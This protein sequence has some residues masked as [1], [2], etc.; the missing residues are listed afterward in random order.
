MMKNSITKTIFVLVSALS[1]LATSSV[2]AKECHK[3]HCTAVCKYI[4]QSDL[5]AT[6]SK[7]GVYRICSN[8]VWNSPGAAITV[9]SDDVTI[10]FKNSFIDI[11]N[12]AGI[13]VEA[14]GVHNL[15]LV[16]PNLL[17]HV[18]A[19]RQ[20]GTYRGLV[21]TNS[22]CLT[23]TNLCAENVTDALFTDTVTAIK[24]DG[25]C[26]NNDTYQLGVT[27][28]SSSNILHTN[29]NSKNVRLS[30]TSSID[31]YFS[32]LNYL[33]DDNNP[34][35]GT[36]T[37]RVGAVLT[38]FIGP[39]PQ[40]GYPSKNLFL[41]DVNIGMQALYQN[42]STAAIGVAGEDIHIERA[43]IT[44]DQEG[45]WRG[46]INLSL[47]P[48][49]Q[50]VVKDCSLDLGG[51]GVGI[52]FAGSY[53]P[54]F[55][56]PG[57]ANY[58]VIDGNRITNAQ[59]GITQDAIV[60]LEGNDVGCLI[61]N[62]HV[63][64]CQIGIA[65]VDANNTIVEHNTVT[66]CY[67]GYADSDVIQGRA[68]AFSALFQ[69]NIAFANTIN[70]SFISPNTVGIDNTDVRNGEPFRAFSLSAVKNVSDQSQNAQM[71]ELF[72]KNKDRMFI[73]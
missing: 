50:I 49:H 42:R 71:A 6:L 73:Q 63:T 2:V 58:C 3:S 36:V 35:G 70:Y 25:V 26:I 45:D 5:P 4:E 11:Q 32:K 38:G 27:Y 67:W 10:E 43:N 1:S 44:F 16:N 52:I 56:L 19:S 61:K 17:G 12:P 51:Q 24:T 9:A 21:V 46:I 22:E 60:D 53:F 69:N 65:P 20:D 15:T 7:H 72:S 33:N 55:G 39:F 57:V 29:E 47:I 18:T 40:Y 37:I 59:V 14:N 30:V 8:L 68:P 41:Q 28:Q 34:T 48:V 13:A 62:N 66:N 31:G 64:N 54:P 23:V